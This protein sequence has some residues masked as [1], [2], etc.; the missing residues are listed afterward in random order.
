MN[1]AQAEVLWVYD[2]MDMKWANWKVR[3][4]QKPDVV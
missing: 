2:K 3:L 1:F 4:A